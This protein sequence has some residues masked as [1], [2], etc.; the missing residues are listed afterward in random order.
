MPDLHGGVY[1]SSR[2]SLSWHT[3]LAARMGTQMDSPEAPDNQQVCC[4]RRGKE[5]SKL[6]FFVFMFMY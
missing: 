4:R 6:N 1:P 5:C 2:T 3:G